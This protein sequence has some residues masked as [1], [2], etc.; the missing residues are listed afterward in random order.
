[1]VQRVSVLN[2]ENNSILQSH[3]IQALS[4]FKYFKATAATS[5]IS[6]A[7]SSAIGEQGRLFYAQRRLASLVKN[8]IDLLTVL[9]IVALLLYYVEV[10]GTA[11]VEMVFVL[12]ILRRTVM[13]AQNTQRSFQRFLDFSGSVRLFRG[14][15]DELAQRTRRCSMSDSVSP[16]LRGSPFVSTTCPSGMMGRA[17]ILDG[18]SVW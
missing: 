15:S 11:F 6:G 9:L 17:P 7:V 3:L 2:T 5:G 8:S 18:Q 4:G 10:L 16:G 14:L 12:V 13:F 1:M